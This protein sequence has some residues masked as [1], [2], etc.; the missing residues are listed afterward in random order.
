MASLS[1]NAEQIKSAADH[2]PSFA[3]TIVQDAVWAMRLPPVQKFVL[4]VLCSR[5]RPDGT[6]LHQKVKTLVAKTGYTQP[7]VSKALGALR[8]AGLIVAATPVGNGHET[9]YDLG[10]ELRQLLVRKVAHDAR[11]PKAAFTPP[12]KQL[13]GNK[14]VRAKRD[15]LRNIKQDAALRELD[16]EALEKPFVSY[17][18]L[19]PDSNDWTEDEFQDWLVTGMKEEF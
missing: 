13:L 10:P 4:S 14:R 5:M 11:T 16:I 12:Q 17:R 3:R 18:H 7:T 15:V 19:K 1:P 2:A 8:K 6:F 9:T